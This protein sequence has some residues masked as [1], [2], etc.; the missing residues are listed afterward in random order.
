MLCKP[1]VLG[2]PKTRGQNKKCPPHPCLLRGP[3]MGTSATQP[4]HSRGSPN[5]GGE[6]EVVASPLPCWGPKRERKCQITPSFS[7]IP[8]QG[9][10]I[11]SGCLTPAFSGA[12]RGA[13]VL[14]NPCVLGR[15]QTT[16]Q[17]EKWQPQPCLLGVQ[18]RAKKLRNPCVVGGPETRRQNQKLQ[19]QTCL[20]GGP[21]RGGSPT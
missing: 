12:Q 7:G 6:P 20:L 17:S 16:G 2:G 18:N 13:H 4:L 11:R 8:Q 14:S 3:K 21:K 9:N 1:C 10:K 5:K 19:P 15:T